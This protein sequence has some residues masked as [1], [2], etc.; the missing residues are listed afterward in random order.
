MRWREKCLALAAQGVDRLVTLRFDD[1]MRETSPQRFV[2]K[3]LVET[4][5][6]RHMVVGDD[7]CYGAKAEGTIYYLRAAGGG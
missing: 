4:L 2:D 1:E 6:V 7:F 3:L 5:G